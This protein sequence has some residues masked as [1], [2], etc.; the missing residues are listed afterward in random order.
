LRANPDK[1]RELAG[2]MNRS[3]L[4]QV[5]NFALAEE[6]RAREGVAKISIEQAEQLAQAVREAQGVPLIGAGFS[7]RSGLPG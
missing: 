7:M 4:F 6:N 5:M 2:L 1:T 3:D